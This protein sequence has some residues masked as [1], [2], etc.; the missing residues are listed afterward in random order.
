MIDSLKT[1]ENS[2]FGHE[3]THI[4]WKIRPREAVLGI[5]GVEVRML[6]MYNGNQ[7]QPSLR[8]YFL[9]LIKKY[10]CTWRSL[11]RA[12]GHGRWDRQETEWSKDSYNFFNFGS[13]CSWNFFY[14]MK[15]TFITKK[16]EKT[17]LLNFPSSSS[18]IMKIFRQTDI[19]VRESKRTNSTLKKANILPSA[20]VN[21]K[22]NK[23]ST[24]KH[25]NQNI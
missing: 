13:D 25:G 3:K 6:K 24:V 9:V 22:T 14:K 20:L 18:R 5:F 10:V 2:K 1:W 11:A 4:K 19:P 12:M 15:L 21:G 8:Q 7:E 16:K 23:N 17:R